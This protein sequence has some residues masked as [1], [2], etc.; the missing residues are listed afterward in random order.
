VL[1]KT[2]PQYLLQISDITAILH[3]PQQYQ[4]NGM[5]CGTI[6]S[7]LVINNIISHIGDFTP[8]AFLMNQFSFLVTLLMLSISAA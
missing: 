6:F 1:G 4:A 5:Y 8:L 2:L 3:Q 7:T